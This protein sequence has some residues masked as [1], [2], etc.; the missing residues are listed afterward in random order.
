[1]SSTKCFKCGRSNSGEDTTCEGCGEELLRGQE[2]ETRFQEL[3]DYRESRTRYSV[4]GILIGILILLLSCSAARWFI[5][6]VLPESEPGPAAVLFREYAP[7]AVILLVFLI[8]V[9]PLILGRW[10][11]RRR[12]RW[13][14]ERVR[15]LDREMRSLPSGFFETPAQGSQA[16][17]GAAR[18]IKGPPTILL[19]IVFGLLALVAL[20][21]FSDLGPLDAVTSLFGVKDAVTVEG[22]YERHYD[23]ADLGGGVSQADQTW[24]YVFRPDGTYTTFLNGHQQYSGKWSQSG[25]VLTVNVPAIA[26]SSAAYSFQATV[27]RDGNS[28]TAGEAEFTKVR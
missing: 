1:M 17:E 11:I 18:K 28:F 23:A 26:G 14:R 24:W 3:K 21:K 9:L 4:S 22:K 27:S 12:Y 10:K 7:P 5:G 15:S 2:Y 19:V 16:A 20:D 6:I 25:N 13:T 8:A